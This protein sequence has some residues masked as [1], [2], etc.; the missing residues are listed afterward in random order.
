MS[1]VKELFAE[2]PD[3]E[4]PT[5]SQEQKDAIVNLWN[6]RTD[7]PPTLKELVQIAFPNIKDVDT[8]TKEGK[9]VKAFIASLRLKALPGYVIRKGLIPLNEH[10]KEYIENNCGNMSA[11]EIAKVLFNNVKLNNLSQEARTVAD[12]IRSLNPKAVYGHDT[13]DNVLEEYR[14]PKKIDSACARVN[15]YVLEGLDIKKLSPKQ[16]KDL[17]S[18]IGYMHTTR[19]LVQINS[20]TRADNRELFESEFIRCTYDKGDLTEEEVDQYIIY[21]S[22]V[23][24][25]KNIHARIE[26]FDNR[27]TELLA[28]G[29]SMS[30]AMVEAISGMRKEH[31]DCIKR[32]QSL[33]SDLQGKRKERLTKIRADNA[34]LV[35]LVETMKSAEKAKQI[36]EFANLRKNALKEEIHRI[37]NMDQLVMEVWGLDPEELLNS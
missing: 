4:G 18:L 3:N 1:D 28:D 17:N 34:S 23:V 33:L 9:L 27:L 8:R 5:L 11:V 37:K 30:N 15:A 26:Q 19:F 21:A 14:P 7:N 6:S 10:Q 25:G 36:V 31:N 20:Y 13:G 12:Y 24:A 29:D 32:Q 22:E 35:Q 2:E 16:V